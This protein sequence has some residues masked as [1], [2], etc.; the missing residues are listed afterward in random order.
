MKIY[1]LKNDNYKFPYQFRLNYQYWKWNIETSTKDFL[2]PFYSDIISGLG[3]ATI[4]SAKKVNPDL[5]K[6]QNN[7]F[8]VRDN[9]VI[10]TV[11]LDNTLILLNTRGQY[12]Y[13]ANTEIS[14]N[15]TG[16][17]YYIYFTDGINEFFSDLFKVCDIAGAEI[18]TNYDL[19][20]N[21]DFSLISDTDISLNS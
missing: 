21:I 20:S 11:T 13:L 18:D 12:Y 15:L 4:F 5:L 2:L 7:Y 1:N 14:P 19:I 8:D 17:I 16:G 10:S 3:S 6:Q 9:A